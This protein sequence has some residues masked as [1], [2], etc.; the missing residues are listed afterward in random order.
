MKKVAD[1]LERGMELSTRKMDAAA[2]KEYQAAGELAFARGAVLAA[3]LLA[4]HEHLV[5]DALGAPGAAGLVAA[6]LLFPR[7]LQRALGVAQGVARKSVV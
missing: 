6:R 2:Y 1:T 3:L 7:L 5:F 4:V